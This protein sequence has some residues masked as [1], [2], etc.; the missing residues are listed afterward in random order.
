M[1]VLPPLYGD[2]RHWALIQADALDL[3]AKLPDQSVDAIVTDPPY[4]IG[5]NGQAWDGRDI[6]AT[7]TPG[8]GQ[9]AA[10]E[11][12]TL[13]WARECLRVLVPG[14]HLVA[15]GATRTVHRLTAGIEDAGFEVRD[16]LAWLYGSGVPKAGLREGRSGTL[17]PG[18]EP[19][20]LARAPLQPN[21]HGAIGDGLLGIDEARINEPGRPIGRWPANLL[22]GHHPRCTRRTCTRACPVSELDRAHPTSRPSRFYYCSKPARRERERGLEALDARSANIFGGRPTQSRRNVHPTVKPVEL[23]RWLVRLTAPTGAV[24]L[25]PFTGSGTTGLAVLAEQRRFVGI[26]RDPEYARIARERL[27]HASAKSTEGGDRARA[28]AG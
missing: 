13:R 27:R 21:R 4:G 26:E 25:D 23:M 14:G 28:P 8:A 16:Q 22:L 7:S 3:L 9:G 5:F 19:I 11:E 20:V 18:Y 24:V 10:F 2:A 6:T 1:S 12:W 17:K 15:F